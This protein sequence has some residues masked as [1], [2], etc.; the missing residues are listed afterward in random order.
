MRGND[1]PKYEKTIESIMTDPISNNISFRKTISMLESYGFVVSSGSGSR[2]K[3]THANL[4]YPIIIHS[5][6]NGSSL[7]PYNIKDIR[8]ALKEVGIV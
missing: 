2:Y 5:H 8:E 3:V 7:K 6:N 1:L 4:K